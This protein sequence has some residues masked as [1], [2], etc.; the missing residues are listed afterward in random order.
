MQRTQP[1]ERPTRVRFVV[2]SLLCMLSFL[3]YFDRVCIM[4]ARDDMQ[5][6]LLLSDAQ[7]GIVMGAFWLAYG[8]FE[9]PSGWIGD[10]VGARFTLTRIVGMRGFS[11]VRVRMYAADSSRF[12]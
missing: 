10:R 8:L 12:F 1:T 7:F 9:I 6:D 4:R 5:R 3:T 11:C 2:M